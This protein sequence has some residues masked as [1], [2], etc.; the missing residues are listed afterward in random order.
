V[1]ADRRVGLDEKTTIIV[2]THDIREAI[3]VSDT[4]WL[5]GR[6][7]GQP[8]ARI[9]DSYDLVARGPPGSPTVV[10]QPAFV[11]LV[12]RAGKSFETL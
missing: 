5:M 3:V 10:R 12:R 9:I 6:D 8:G 7:S 11:E 4:L 2:V 1:R